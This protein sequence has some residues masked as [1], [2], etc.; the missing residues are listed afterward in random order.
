MPENFPTS[1]ENIDTKKSEHLKEGVL[2]IMACVG[3]LEDFFNKKAIKENPFIPNPI[4]PTKATTM[5]DFN[6][7]PEELSK[8]NIKNAGRYTY[9]ISPVDERDKISSKFF[10]CTGIVACGIDKKTGQNISFLSH[11]N[12][13]RFLGRAQKQFLADLRERIMEL[14]EKSTEGTVD[15][16]IVGGQYVDLPNAEEERARYLESIRLLGEEVKKI[17]GFEP[18]VITGP[19][20]WGLDGKEDDTVFFQNEGRRLY[21]IRPHV[22]DNST[23]SFL[24]SELDAQ[25]EKW[26]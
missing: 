20:L 11:Q 15:V 21:I 14:K 19:K 4:N 1:P 8:E 6:A 9:V 23:E 2:P 7:K 18:V 10:D 13:E 26:V 12:P 16:V 22:G 17:M 3:T 24:P 25:K 5:V